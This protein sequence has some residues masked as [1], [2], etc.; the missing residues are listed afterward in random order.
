MIEKVCGDEEF[1]D[2]AVVMDCNGANGSV[3]YKVEDKVEKLIADIPKTATNVKLSTST[4]S[5]KFL[6]VKLV[7]PATGKCVVGYSG[8]GCKFSTPGDHEYA[9]MTIYYTGDTVQDQH[10]KLKGSSTI[11]LQFFAA[12]WGVLVQSPTGEAGYSYDLIRDCPAM[13]PGCKTCSDY[14]GCSEGKAPVCD[15]TYKV[16]CT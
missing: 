11:P 12:P 15:G 5:A 13:A 16:K 6:D 7:D 8:L 14:A 10:V 4:E 2:A 1:Q 9:N 3:H